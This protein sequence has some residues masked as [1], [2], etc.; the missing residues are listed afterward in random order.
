MILAG[1]T[2]V[3]L[4]SGEEGTGTGGAGGGIDRST[5]EGVSPSAIPLFRR[6]DLNRG[7]E[8]TDLEDRI[9]FLGAG[10]VGRIAGDSFLR[11][12]SSS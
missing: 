6:D 12:D 5:G 1:V 10:F 11:D 3:R 8:F 7:V 4:E 2:G 9:D